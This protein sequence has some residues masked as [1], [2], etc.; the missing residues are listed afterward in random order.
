MLLLVFGT[1]GGNKWL[2]RG[3]LF[4]FHPVWQLFNK[5]CRSDHRRLGLIC[6]D[7]P[8]AKWQNGRN[9]GTATCHILGDTDIVLLYY[10]IIYSSSFQMNLWDQEERLSFKGDWDLPPL[11]WALPGKEDHHHQGRPTTHHQAPGTTWEF[12][13]ENW[14]GKQNWSSAQLSFHKTD[15]I[16]WFDLPEWKSDNIG[17]DATRLDDYMTIWLHD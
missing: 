7:S 17:S 15:Y 9:V 14:E 8:F 16:A 2:K 13:W 4:Q 1:R 3:R 12:L 11:L 5:I 10:C 6:L